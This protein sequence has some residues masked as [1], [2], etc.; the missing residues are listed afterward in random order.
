MAK[1]DLSATMAATLAEAIEHGGK[2]VRHQGGY[3][4]RPGAVMSATIGHP[5]DWWVG[6][7]TLNALVSRGKMRFTEY[8]EGR[9]YR[10]PIAA[11]VVAEDAA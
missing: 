2:L 11:E 4:T 7:A 3:W 8:R 5:F 1:G 10:F 6:T 9:G